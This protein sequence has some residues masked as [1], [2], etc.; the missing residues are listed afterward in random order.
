LV[1]TYRSK[2]WVLGQD[3]VF[4]HVAHDRFDWGEAR[5]GVTLQNGIV[6][7][8]V[9]YTDALDTGLAAELQDLL[10]GTA[11]TREVLTSL[12]CTHAQ[13]PLGDILAL[14]LLTLD[15]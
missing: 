13:T 3:K 4:D 6:T 11:F 2:P 10:A 9:L 8:A 5:V 14:L 15:S 1:E 12:C 7:D